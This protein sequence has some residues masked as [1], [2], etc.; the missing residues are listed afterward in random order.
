[1]SGSTSKFLPKYLTSRVSGKN[2]SL[3][4]VCDFPQSS[5]THHPTCGLQQQRSV[6]GFVFHAQNYGLEHSNVSANSAKLRMILGSRKAN[7]HGPQHQPIPDE[8]KQL[9]VTNDEEKHSE[10]HQPPRRSEAQTRRP[11]HGSMPGR[12]H[13]YFTKTQHL[14][15]MNTS[16]DDT[17]DSTTEIHQ[18][19]TFVDSFPGLGN[20]TSGLTISLATKMNC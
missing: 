17:N 8:A 14:T 19:P 15:Q 5:T 3:G 6:S 18:P 7:R 16:R 13:F 9:P 11:R 12:H 2:D 20:T 4:D 10:T 1:M